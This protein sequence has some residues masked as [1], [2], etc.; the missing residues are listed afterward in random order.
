M[1]ADVQVANEVPPAVLLLYLE[2]L[3]VSEVVVLTVRTKLLFFQPS[4]GE[5]V[6]RQVNA[7]VNFE[8]NARW[9][10]FTFYFHL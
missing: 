10:P 8:R 9:L 1:L 5:A 6:K 3:L 4:F 2:L 7:V